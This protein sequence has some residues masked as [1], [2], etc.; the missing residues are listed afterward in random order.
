MDKQFSF[1][2]VGLYGEGVFHGAMFRNAK[3]I[4]IGDPFTIL[5]NLHGINLEQFT[6]IMQ[7]AK[8]D[9]TILKTKFRINPPYIIDTLDLARHYDARMKHDLDSLC[10]LFKLPPKGDTKQF[11][12]LHWQDMTLLQRI[13]LQSYTLNDVD[14]EWKLFQIL[15]PLLSNPEMEILLARHT[16]QLYLEPKIKFDFIKA[17][18]L[19]G[20]M[21]SE[22]DNIVNQT[23]HTQD[24]LSGNKS[25]VKLLAEALPKGE[26]VPMKL[27]KHGNIP[28]LAKD[29]EAFQEL[30]AHS[31]K[32]VRNL[33]SA[34]Q[35][36]RSWPLHFARIDSMANQADVSGGFLRIPLHY[37]GGHTGRWS[38]SEGINV[39]NLGSRGRAG[40]GVHPLISDMRTM[41]TAPDDYTFAIVDSAQVEARI[42]AWLAGQQ[43]L[44]DAF[45]EGKDIYS[46]FATTL[47]GTLVYKSN[48][49]DPKPV[50]RILDIRR[51]FGKDAIL[52]C[53]YGMGAE[54]FYKR[55]RANQD[56]RPLFDSGEYNF[57]FIEKLIKT[58]RTTYQRIPD[59][60]NRIEKLFKNVIKYSNENCA[61][62]SGFGIGLL[63]LWNQN[64][65]IY[66]Q[67]PSKRTL[68]YRHCS[69]DKKGKI[70]WHW[71]HLWGG[72]ITENIVQAIAR[73][74]LGF[75]IFKLEDNYIKVVMHNHDEA[76]C[77]VKENDINIL[78]DIVSILRT[79]PQWAT[80]LPLDAEGKLSKV[81]TK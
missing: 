56:L 45:A 53:G 63:R 26:T 43:D 28:A 33:C 65:N 81:Y 77:L 60:W 22:L 79:T 23:S 58:Y 36:V 4:L 74:L 1:N 78:D 20:K 14:R 75:W 13:D 10:K 66:I 59:F 46:E 57:K 12:G 76:V 7:N 38:G 67:L 48:E 32:Q 25:F 3:D 6:V 72:S 61:Y 52:G 69:I 31:N 34:R 27:G 40:S 16:L 2:A 80:G 19:K 29:D 44:V 47:F 11:K 24:E 62:S 71:G 54:K 51:G 49:D 5:K 55:C 9:A 21:I 42:L 70:K 15:L 35:A 50:K 64:G 41:L 37:Y 8:F 39:Q 73:D 68:I 17:G 18:E 30:L